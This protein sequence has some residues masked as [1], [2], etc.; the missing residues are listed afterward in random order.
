MNI[1]PGSSIVV[2]L[3]K[4]K[5]RMKPRLARAIAELTASIPDIQ[6][7]YLFGCIMN[8]MSKPAEVLALVF[9]ASFEF[10]EAIATLCRDL[11]GVLP[12][13]TNLDVW[14]I[15]PPN[16][17]LG[18]VRLLGRR[19]FVRSPN[20]EPIFSAEPPPERKWWQIW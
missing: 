13:G 15:A 17:T 14:P 1:S 8:G 16:S 9:P 10:K 3:L 6:E 19:L 11:R 20:G 18:S 7:A 5:Q 2:G 4:K 12:P